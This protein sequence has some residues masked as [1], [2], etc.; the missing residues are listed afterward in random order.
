MGQITW[1]CPKCVADMVTKR[2]IKPLGTYYP[3][4]EIP[5][6]GGFC[7]KCGSD[8]NGNLLKLPCNWR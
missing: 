4:N 1:A 5:F 2:I 6:T 3:P 7:Q 8:K